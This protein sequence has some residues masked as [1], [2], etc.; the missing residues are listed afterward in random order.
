[1]PYHAKQEPQKPGVLILI[2]DKTSLKKKKAPRS[3]KHVYLC[4]DWLSK[5]I[6]V[7][8]KNFGT[9]FFAYGNSFAI[10]QSLV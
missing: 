7:P 8:P 9:N 3:L 4:S 6:P 2:L 5:P 1:M 10:L